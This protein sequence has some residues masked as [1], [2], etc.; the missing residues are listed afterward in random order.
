L[1]R[2]HSVSLPQ[3]AAGPSPASEAE[4][5]TGTPPRGAVE[6]ETA[7]SGSSR[8]LDLRRYSPVA[9]ST[10]ERRAANEAALRVLEKPDAA[11]T[12][13][14]RTD[15]LRLYTGAGGVGQG[16]G[17]DALIGLLN[18]HYTSYG[19]VQMI[20]DKLG[21]MGFKAG[22]VLEPGAGVGNFAGFRPP[23]VEMV[24]VERNPVS[25]RIARLLYPEQQVH[26]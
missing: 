24:M 12:E 15:V 18:E 8:D 20:W 10:K 5:D 19:I 11:I 14:D 3:T 7:P 21:R 17:T 25:A 9:L 13:A 22:N 16:E 23:G 6:H 4:R 2:R 26:H 1:A